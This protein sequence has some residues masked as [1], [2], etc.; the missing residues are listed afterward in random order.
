MNFLKQA[1]SE[2]PSG[3]ATSGKPSSHRLMIFLF[4]ADV[5]TVWTINTLRT[6][7]WTMDSTVLLA[8][9]SALGIGAWRRGKETTTN[10]PTKGTQ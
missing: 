9:I 5:M 1:F 4:V 2:A 3:A 10:Q 8:V 6:P 7:A